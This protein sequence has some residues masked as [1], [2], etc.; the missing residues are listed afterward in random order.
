MPEKQTL[1]RA[2]KAKLERKAASTEAG[3]FVQE[4]IEHI[5]RGKHGVRSAFCKG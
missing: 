1:R 5:R 3:E 2:R 4:E